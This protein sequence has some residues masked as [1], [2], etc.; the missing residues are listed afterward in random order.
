MPLLHL[1]CIDANDFP[2]M[3]IMCESHYWNWSFHDD[4]I[5]WKHFPRYWPFVR[6]I[7]RSPV[8]FPHKGH[9]RGASMW[10]LICTWTKCCINHRDAADLRRHRA[11]YIVIVMYFDQLFHRRSLHQYEYHEDISSGSRYFRFFIS[12]V[13]LCDATIQNIFTVKY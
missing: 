11:H 4:V 2:W 5:K 3:W 7:H 6:G 10:F 13:I 8:D 9:W 12:I 1:K